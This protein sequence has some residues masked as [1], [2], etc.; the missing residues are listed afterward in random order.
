MANENTPVKN[1]GVTQEFDAKVV[2]ENEINESETAQIENE[3]FLDEKE[4]SALEKS[5]DK[6]NEDILVVEKENLEVFGSIDSPDKQYNSGKTTVFTLPDKQEIGADIDHEELSLSELQSNAKSYFDA[7]HTHSIDDKVNE[8]CKLADSGFETVDETSTEQPERFARKSENKKRKRRDVVSNDDIEILVGDFNAEK[9]KETTADSLDDSELTEQDSAILKV[10]GKNDKDFDNKYDELLNDDEPEV[11]YTDAAQ[12]ST[13]LKALR[14]DALKKLAFFVLSFVFTALCVY[15]ETTV[16][17]NSARPEFLTVGKYSAVNALCMLQLM[18]FCVMFNLDGLKRGFR[19]FNPSKPAAES[20]VIVSVL[21]CAVQSVLSALVAGDNPGMRTYCSVGCIALLCLSVNSFVKAYTTLNSFCIVASKMPKFATQELD[22]T[23]LEAAAFSKYLE[24][25]TTI[26]TVGR[27]DFITG[28]FKKSIAVPKALKNSFNISIVS[29]VVGIAVGVISGVLSQNV[30]SAVSSG[31]FVMLSVLPV[32]IL[33]SCALPHLIASLK[34]M[35]TKTALIGEGACDTYTDTGIIS[36]DDTEVFPPKNVKVTSIRTYGQTRIDK[37]IIYMARIFDKVGGPLSFVFANSIQDD[38]QNPEISIIEHAADG[39][40]LMVD[41]C[42]VYIGT[43][44]FMKLYDITTVSDSVDESFLQSLGSILYMSVDGEL[45]AKFYI[46]YTINPNFEDVLHSM[47]DAGVCVGINSLDPCINNELVIGNLKNTNYP[48][49]V[50]KK[51]EKSD[52]ML[53][54]SPTSS[55]SIIS[56]SGLHS[57]LKGF[58][59]LDNLRSCY[60]SN[61]LITMFC[62]IVGAIISAVIVMFNIGNV[63]SIIFVLLFQLIW[64]L[65]TTIFS[66]L[67]K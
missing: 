6:N 27:S 64:C 51:F 66:V 33:L 42:Q 13:I 25:D 24:A 28:F 50:I 65:P 57:F 18:C 1:N 36:F 39:L 55:G 12:D 40:K 3:S 2:S 15:F 46:K 63:P 7:T 16:A 11:E 20:I 44:N 9:S 48:V 67:N 14:I 56:L 45:S 10:F 19:G 47:Y 58:I 34:C 37:V 31:T 4:F 21:A 60:R 30:Y 26:F 52:T 8:L 41:D 59:C 61:A 49:S 35:K 38:C 62:A 32:N 22:S 5:D 17:T 43:S 29:I 54:V 53:G 23:S